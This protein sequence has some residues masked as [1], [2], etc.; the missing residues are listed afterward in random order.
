MKRITWPTW[1][2]AGLTGLCLVSGAG[3]IPTTAC[4]AAFALGLTL[5]L[6]R[7]WRVARKR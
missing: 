5:D 1:A 3:P 2:A 7:P 6:T 4:T